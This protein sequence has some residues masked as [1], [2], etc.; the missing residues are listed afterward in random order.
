MPRRRTP[1]SKRAARSQSSQAKRNVDRP[2]QAHVCAVKPRNAPC[3]L[4]FAAPA[5]TSCANGLVFSSY[6]NPATDL[7]RCS[8]SARSAAL[9]GQTLCVRARRPCAAI[10]LRNAAAANA[11]LRAKEL[12]CLFWS[13]RPTDGFFL[14]PALDP[15]NSFRIS[16]LPFGRESWRRRTL[17]HV[18]PPCGFFWGSETSQK[19]LEQNKSSING[20]SNG[21]GPS[22][23]NENKYDGSRNKR[24]FIIEDGEGSA[25]F[26][27]HRCKIERKH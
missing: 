20:L 27:F 18:E 15:F 9:R 19:I 4:L 21:Y 10:Q 24:I 16:S 14:L 5:W 11:L 25:K 3:C 6:L 17:C 12:A 26:K 2:A 7:M 22:T 23:L 8:G 1:R 13:Y